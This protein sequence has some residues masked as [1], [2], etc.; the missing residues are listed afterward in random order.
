RV[1]ELIYRRFVASQMA[2]AVWAVTNVEVTATPTEMVPLLE[3]GFDVTATGLFKARG[4]V[5][6]F[7]GWRRVLKAHTEE[8]PLP[9]LSEGQPLDR[10]GLTASQHFTQPPDRYNE[11]S[12]IKA[13]ERDG[14]GRPSTYVPIIGKIT[15]EKR[16]YIEVR[17]RKFHATELGKKVTDLLV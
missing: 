15:S 6:K 1:Y 7:D 16:G 2:P 13:L 9:P 8:G 14:I 5:L 3:A 4:R 17:D 11:A 12:L 10:L